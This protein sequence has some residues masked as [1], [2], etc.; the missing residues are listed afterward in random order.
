MKYYFGTEI[1]LVSFGG[2]RHIGMAFKPV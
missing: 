2:L 1:V